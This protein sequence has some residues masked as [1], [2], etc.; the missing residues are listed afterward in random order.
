[1]I[2]GCILTGGQNRRMAGEKK[3]FLPYEGRPFLSHLLDALAELPKVYLSVDRPEPYEAA[4]LPMVPDRWP[5][6]GPMGGIASVLRACGEE[7]V[8]VT[9]C[10]TP[11]L[12]RETVQ[13][14][15]S[16]W[17]GGVLLVSVDGRIQP[18]LGIY[19]KSA[20][21][22][23]EKRLAKGELRMYDFLRAFGYVELP[24]P[25]RS[26]AAVN[27]NTP[28]DYRALKRKTE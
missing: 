6:C 3:L 2:A 12:D 25:E 1:M 4:Q 14:L 21:P 17:Q 7:A 8:F 22:E 20:L 27:I 10:D 15:V 5:N 18:L 9:A 24:L 13:Q 11:L 16:A 19:P 28:E 23:L 26:Q